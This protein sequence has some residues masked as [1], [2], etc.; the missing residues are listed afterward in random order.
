MLLQVAATCVMLYMA[1]AIQRAQIALFSL[2]GSATRPILKVANRPIGCNYSDELTLPRVYQ[3]IHARDRSRF[4]KK[5]RSRSRDF[6]SGV[7][8]GCL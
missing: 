3:R 8:D 1:V 6:L 7:L 5:I 4:A 2:G